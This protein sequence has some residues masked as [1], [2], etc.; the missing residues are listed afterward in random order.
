MDNNK[1]KLVIKETCMVFFFQAPTKD[2]ICGH[3][4]L[5][6][7]LYHQEDCRKYSET[8]FLLAA[9]SHFSVLMAVGKILKGSQHD[10]HHHHNTINISN[11]AIKHTEQCYSDI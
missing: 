9:H 2:M 8:S 11:N 10:S 6:N 3:T 1:M 4:Y 5:N 7:A